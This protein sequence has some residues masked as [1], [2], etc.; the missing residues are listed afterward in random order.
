[1]SVLYENTE[2]HC[3]YVHFS[4]VTDC[5]RLFPEKTGKQDPELSA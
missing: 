2:K 5:Y 3:M 1:M 4:I